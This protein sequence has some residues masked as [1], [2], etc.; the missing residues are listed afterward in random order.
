MNAFQQTFI[1]NFLVQCLYK[2][3]VSENLLKMGVEK[4]AYKVGNFEDEAFK[5]VE[6]VRKHAFE[7]DKAKAAVFEEEC[8]AMGVFERDKGGCRLF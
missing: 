2:P 3:E 8:R 1:K 7:G 6:A 4:R 5:T